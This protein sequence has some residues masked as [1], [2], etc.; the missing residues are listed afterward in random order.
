MADDK[1]HDEQPS[2]TQK[3]EGAHVSKVV[4]CG[5]VGDGTVG[6]SCLLMTYTMAGFAEHYI[7]T[8]FDNFSVIEEFDGK[9]VNITLWDTAGQDDYQSFRTST[10]YKN[11]DVFLVCFSV[12]SPH[13][14]QNV[15]QKWIPELVEHCP[16]VPFILVG[17]QTD[18]RDDPKTL[19]N[20]Q[21][22][23]A[24][25]ITSKM[26]SK[27]SKDIKALCYLECSARDI[28]SVVQIFRNA[29]MFLLD[30]DYKRMLKIQKAAKKEAA[31]E[32]KYEKR[33]EKMRKSS[34]KKNTNNSS[35][36]HDSDDDRSTA[37]A[38]AGPS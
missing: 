19:E 14:F 18:L 15:K 5:I 21:A 26:G 24:T 4:K 22:S 38:A 23:N 36:D 3:R 35:G 30:K 32:K 10:C 20:L 12:V 33:L 31:L 9:L 25:P 16:G 13:S 2:R 7:P 1:P 17:T 8:I 28:S 29:C 37:A 27:R 6:K 11:T 34:D